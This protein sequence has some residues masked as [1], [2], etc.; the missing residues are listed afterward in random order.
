M[1]FYQLGINV[2]GAGVNVAIDMYLWGIFVCVTFFLSLLST[3]ISRLG[4]PNGY[5]E[6]GTD[7]TR[8]KKSFYREIC[9]LIKVHLKIDR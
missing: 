1:Y 4:Y 9:E 7:S 3:R 2:Y 8:F 5:N 6:G